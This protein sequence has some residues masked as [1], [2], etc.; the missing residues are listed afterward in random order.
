MAAMIRSVV[1]ATTS[2]VTGRASR[3][4]ST[5]GSPA[6]M[7]RCLRGKTSGFFE[8]GGRMSCAPHCPTGMTGHPVASAIRAAPDLPVIGQSSG[9]RVKVPSG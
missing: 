1:L 9:S 4:S 8:Y 7:V 2:V 3:S 6:F 5:T